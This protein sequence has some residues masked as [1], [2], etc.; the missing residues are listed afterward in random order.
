MRKE[1][2]RCDIIPVKKHQTNVYHDV[3]FFKEFTPEELN[4][5]LKN[6]KIT[7][8]KAGSIIFTTDDV[9][10]GTSLHILKSGRV[11]LFRVNIHGKRIITRRIMPGSI[12]GL[13]AFLGKD[14]EGNF[15][16]AAIDSV[17]YKITRE[18]VLDLFKGKPEISLKIID[19]FAHRLM[20][21]EKRFVDM[22]YS[23]VSARIAHFLLVNEERET[24]EIQ[25]ITHEEIG[26]LVGAVRQTVT[27]NLNLLQK[28]GLIKM[29]PKTIRIIDRNGLARV[30]NKE[31]HIRQ[32]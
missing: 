5:F 3:D 17:T 29:G 31:P 4:Q 6:S 12:F 28:Q 32:K 7:E 11:N 18:N 8:Y 27:E 25:G 22:A 1:T 14:L 26:E 16:E 24:G 23:P 10:T 20:M 2:P 19:V 13:L 30:I 9:V 21:I 15:A